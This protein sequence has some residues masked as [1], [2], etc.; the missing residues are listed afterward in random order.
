MINVMSGKLFFLPLLCCLLALSTFAQTAERLGTVSFSVSCAPAQQAAFN[1][2]VSLVHDFWYEE[3]QRQFEAIA[4]A[5]PSCAMARWGIGM[6]IYHQIWN[7]PGPTVMARGWSELQQAT[8]AKTDR[9]RDYI[10]ALTNFYKPG[11]ETFEARVT[12]YSSAMSALHRR[13]PDDVDAAAF[14]ALSL[15]ADVGPGDT[16]LTKEREA[17]SLIAPLFDKYPDHPGLA[18]YIIHACDNPSMARQSLHAAQRYGVIAP[19]GAHAAHMGGHI[20]ARLGMWKEDIDANRA[21]VDAAHAAAKTN[22]GGGFDELH[23]DEFLLYAYL[24]NGDDFAA[25]ALLD[26]TMIGLG[27]MAGMPNSMGDGMESMVS[28][29]STELPVFYSL[30]RR[31]WKTVAA[32][33]TVKG[34]PASVQ[35]LT[36]WARVIANGH[37]KDGPAAKADLAKYE[38]LV[39]EIKKGPDAYAAESTGAQ[40]SDGTVRAWGAY[41]QGDNETAL[42]LLRVAADL[43]DKV[44]Q[45]EVDIPVREMLADM[46]LDLNRPKEALVEYE[47]A[48]QL[49]PNR[50][51]GLYNAGRAAEAS[52]DKKKARQFYATLL[53]ITGNGER[54]TRVEI[55]HAKAFT[56]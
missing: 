51:N 50:F 10:A 43:Q 42:K 23:P 14:Y 4:K 2:G 6:S 5:D 46:L 3:A 55:E 16:S 54:S 44:G 45:G 53:R 26:G 27:V 40:I 56:K 52:G 20:F 11:N 30:E 9:E 17:M 34:A 7:R 49:S 21:A 15:L 35:T 36:Y 12:V 48:L 13:F 47:R 38:S 39:E 28:Y 29:Y 22:R 24:Q 8:N 31:D 18:H 19:S 25:K 41:A 32:M 37:L 1:R 33:Q